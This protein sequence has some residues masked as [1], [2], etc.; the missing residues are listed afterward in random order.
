M[1]DKKTP[2]FLRLRR[3]I[4]E[5]ASILFWAFLIVKLAIFDIDDSLIHFLFP[6][7]DWL[8]TYKFVF[9]LLTLAIF[10]L[11]LGTKRAL[12][13]ALYMLA[14]PLI[15]FSW[16]VPKILSGS[17]T[18]VIFA[19]VGAAILTLK[20][21]KKWFISFAF[22]LAACAMILINLGEAFT[23]VATL[24]LFGLLIKHYFER[25]VSAFRPETVLSGINNF[26]KNQWTAMREDILFKEIRDSSK[27]A[28][29]S[30]E[31]LKKRF[32]TIK[33]LLLLNQAVRFVAENLKRFHESRILTVY[34][35]LKLVYTFV[36]TVI[37]FGFAY[38]SLNRISPGSFSVGEDANLFLF[39]YYSFNTFLTMGV[40]DINALTPLAR[41]LTTCELLF[42]ILLGVILVFIF[43]TIIREKYEDELKELIRGLETEST[44]LCSAFEHEFNIS[45]KD[46]E[47]EV[48]EKE[49]NLLNLLNHLRGK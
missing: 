31:Y 24:L 44:K 18:N 8:M 7:H 36:T 25:L 41:V 3:F 13:T 38:F 28:P 49:P 14:Y 46:I 12:L 15:V 47:I 20:S 35:I 22:S 10:W 39:L 40:A 1:V 9:V 37:I 45:L 34:S 26:L 33:S 43:T 2:S 19:G 29:G 42:S 17:S 48:R 5:S 30:E 4:R 21:A 6:E 11:S 23:V 27:Y 16:K 32:E